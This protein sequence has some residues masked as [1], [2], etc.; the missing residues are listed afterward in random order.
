[1]R[2]RMRLR[3]PRRDEETVVNPWVASGKESD[4]RSWAKAQMELWGWL[5]GVVL[6][7]AGEF[8]PKKEAPVEYDERGLPILNLTQEDIQKLLAIP[9]TVPDV[10]VPEDDDL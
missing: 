6:E 3:D 10:S 8:E 1:M 2:F 4:A 7:C 5:N 9:K